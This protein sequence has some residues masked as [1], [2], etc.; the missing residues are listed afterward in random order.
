VYK[1]DILTFEELLT[2]LKKYIKNK[3]ELELIKKAYM[4]AYE[5]HF[6]QKRKSGEDYIIHP[7]NVAYILAGINADYKTICSALLHDTIEDCDVT[8]EEI[9]ELFGG[10]VAYLV[11]SLTKINK[12]NFSCDSEATIAN[13]RKILVGLTEDVRVIILKLADRLH[14]MRTLWALP[15]KKQKENAK[16]TLDIF[17]P[18]AHRLGMN[19]IKSELED[20]CLRYSKPDVY[21]Q[22]V[23]KLNKKKSERDEAVNEMKNTVSKLLNSHNIK[24][25]IKGR[26]KSIY[27]IYKK[28]DTGRSFNDIY[29]FLALRVFVKTEEECYQVLGIIHSKFK[30]IPKR[31]KDYIAMPKTN[32][33][34][35]LHTSV[36]GNNGEIFEIQIRTYEMDK[37]AENGIASH[38]SYKE[39]KKANLQSEMEQK[40]QFFRLIMEL[41]HEGTNDQEFVDS[42]KE[43]VLKDTIYVF[44][45]QGDVLELPNGSTPI[46]FAY[47]VHTRVGDTMVGAIV[48]NNIVPLDYKLKDDDIVKINTNKNSPGPS[49]EWLN[50]AKTTHAKNKIRSFFNKN[51]K[52]DYVNRGEDLI[53]KELRKRKLSNSVFNENLNKILQE[54][55]CSDLNDLYINVGNNKYTPSQ[56]I[57][58]ITGE[59]T[60]KEELLIKKTQNKEVSREIA[61]NDIIVEGIDDIKVNIASCCKPIKDDEIIGYIT[62][63]YGITIHRI[64]CPNVSELQERF[65][66]VRWNSNTSKKY[67][68]TLLLKSLDS[69]NMLFDI[70]AKTTNRNVVVESIN[71]IKN[72]ECYTCEL[73]ISVDN[74]EQLNKFINDLES[75][76]N[77]LSVERLIK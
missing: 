1:E 67:P 35:S 50:I 3:K 13:Q 68:T 21:F 15:E 5:K 39:K 23:E 61:K 77:M 42:V 54:F 14:N 38:W 63:G 53:S 74:L 25:E 18:I 29:D 65:I 30:P 72:N 55:K 51:E 41:K 17:I 44:T 34:Q 52:E 20:L 76:P 37:I 69:K 12:L 36:F 48:N 9:E 33:Y 64:N 66:S 26:S 7:L 40:L 6:G 46:D 4:Y 59:N 8:K 58:L 24:H 2:R 31:F 60:T 49:R 10:E 22:I 45:P 70:I 16:E 27:S 11:E 75:I 57:N 19:S 71:N 56:I 32:M 47:R 73:T 43:D 28:L 62:K